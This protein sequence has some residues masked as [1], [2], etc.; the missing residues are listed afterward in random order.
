MQLIVTYQLS[1]DENL[2]LKN[3]TNHLENRHTAEKLIKEYQKYDQRELYQSVMNI[4][5]QVN[6]DTFKEKKS[7]LEVLREI[8]RDEL[9]EKREIGIKQSEVQNLL[10]LVQKKLE[11]EKTYEVIAEELEIS[12]T[13]VEH[14]G[15]IIKYA[16]P[17]STLEDLLSILIEK[18]IN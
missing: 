6:Q 1:E 2:W 11:K 14:I 3:I 18:N 15:E 13:I 12:F 16:N 7:M 9:E 4:I 10:K 17:N 8:F 5:I